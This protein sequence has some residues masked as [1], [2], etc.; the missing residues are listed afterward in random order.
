MKSAKCDHQLRSSQAVNYINDGKLC[1]LPLEY[2]TCLAC[3]KQWI[4]DAINNQAVPHPTA[5]SRKL[6]GAFMAVAD[7]ER[8]KPAIIVPAENQIIA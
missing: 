8:N 3:F 1:L 6:L 7:K 2:L 4:L 5:G